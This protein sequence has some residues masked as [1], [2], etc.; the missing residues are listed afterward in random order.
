MRAKVISH[1]GNLTSGHYVAM[2]KNNLDNNWYEFDDD[3]IKVVQD[4]DVVTDSGYLLFYQR[5]SAKVASGRHWCLRMPQVQKALADA[6]T[7][8][9]IEDNEGKSCKL[10]IHENSE[11]EKKNYLKI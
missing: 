2:S 3:V 7:G 5:K 9:V 11:N 6:R 1:H 8:P 10:R 4:H